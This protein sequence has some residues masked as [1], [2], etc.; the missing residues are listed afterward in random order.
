MRS[1]Y[2]PDRAACKARFSD[3]NAAWRAAPLSN[4][5][6]NALVCM[7]NSFAL[8]KPLCESMKIPGIGEFG[9][10]GVAGPMRL[11][12]AGSGDVQSDG[13]DR[14][15]HVSR[16]HGRI[17]DHPRQLDCRDLVYAGDARF[18]PDHESAA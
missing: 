5:R 18:R 14:P 11:A 3:G 7:F 8:A 2:E 4:E 1:R 13:V 15:L 6:I 9:S 10:R 17:P 12:W 16:H